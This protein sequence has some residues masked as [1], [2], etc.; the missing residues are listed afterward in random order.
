MRMK[1]GGGGGGGGSVVNAPGS[2][3]GFKLYNLDGG[4]GG[5]GGGEADG[6]IPE[7]N[8]QALMLAAARKRDSGHNERFYEEIDYERRCRKRKARLI[9][10]TEEAFAHIKRL[11][12]EKAPSVPMDAD[13]AAKAIFPTF[14]RS[15]SKFLRVTRQQPRHS[16]E[17]VIRHLT[18]CLSFDLGP[19]AFLER[20]FST[21]ETFEVRFLLPSSFLD[22]S[23]V[24][25]FLQASQL[26]TKWSIL[27]DEIASRDISHG[28]TFS[29]LCHSPGPDS[30]SRLLTLPSSAWMG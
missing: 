17:Q 22:L 16:A 30:G 19:R 5:G 10:A 29:L 14:A 20:F 11:N 23:E 2:Q 8:A 24:R 9:T 27:T 26:E 1:S 4:G 18:E 7:I 12:Q 28:T 21:Q 15:L 13:E 6:S 25:W 3:V